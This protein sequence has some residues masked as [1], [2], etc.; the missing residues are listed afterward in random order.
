M[1]EVI[2]M[3]KMSD[4]M[5]EGVLVKWFKKEGDLLK[6]GDILA[7]VETDK[8]VMELEN[9]EEGVLLHI[10]VAEG[11]KVPVDGLIAVVGE[12]EEEI[13]SLLTE[14]ASVKA[15]L[16]SS[17]EVPLVDSSSV[18]GREVATEEASSSAVV[19][20]EEEALSAKE[21]LSSV[22]SSSEERLKVSPLARKM[23]KEKGYDLYHIQGSGEG[24][25]IVKRDILAHT[26][27]PLV[28]S[29]S[30]FT[31]EERY[32]DVP[33]SQMRKTIASRL[34]ESKFTA[35][36][37][38][39]RTEAEVSALV[40][41]RSRINEKAEQKISFND[42]IV[43]ASASALR[44]Y[45]SVNSSWQ[46]EYIRQYHHIHVGVAVAVP[47]GLLVPVLRFADLKG[48]YEISSEIKQLA[49]SARDR[50]LKPEQWAGS[51]FSISNLGMY[52]IENF[53]AIINTPNACILAVGGILD[54]PVVQK[55]EI[56]P[57]KCLQLTLSCDHRVVDGATG[58]AFLN[59]LKSM[60]EEPLHMLL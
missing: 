31:A 8:A 3:P 17:K 57:G 43:K 24:G 41:A 39:L 2:R 22:F 46:G 1:A 35:P 10:A 25:R 59:T 11:K 53:T 58:A 21:K 30:S 44:Q 40:A 4:T 50:S 13:E 5:E 6:V 16:E 34:S 29:S 23:A 37:F 33:V 32:T 51:T 49:S 14:E 42:L 26:S 28:V 18:D 47:D 56:V 15:P 27:S 48:L 45:S 52:G 12:K 9:Y 38:Y 55:G 7:E 19:A 60:L 36:H 20:A 54:K